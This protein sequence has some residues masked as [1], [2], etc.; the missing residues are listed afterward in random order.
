[1]GDVSKEFCGGTHVSHTGDIECF[2][3]VYE[4]SVAAGIRRIEARTGIEA[5]DYLKQKDVLLN[6]IMGLVKAGSY[7]EISSRINALLEENTRFKKDNA[8]LN[9][10]VSNFKSKE[11]EN[12]FE[13]IN[14]KHVLCKKVN[15]MNKEMFSNLFDSLKVKFDSSIVVLANVCDDRI[16]FIA[17]VSKDLIS[18][19]KAGNIIKEVTSI[20]GGSGGGR[21][22]VAQ[23]GG[24]DSSKI[25]EAFE[26]VKKSF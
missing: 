20:C 13:V 11:I 26:Q 18:Q 15:N 7:G 8:T 4:E 5:Y 1:M 17:S 23:G 6:S 25:D 22:D 16:S 21:P 9:Q 3:L 14:G 10:E 19:Y 24:K 12:E 2:A